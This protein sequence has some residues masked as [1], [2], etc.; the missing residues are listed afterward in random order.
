M[1]TCF[2][3]Y[4]R[5]QVAKIVSGSCFGE[6]LSSEL[7]MLEGPT[8]TKVQHANSQSPLVTTPMAHGIDALQQPAHHLLHQIMR[9]LD[10]VHQSSKVL[11]PAI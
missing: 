8:Q 10:V 4:A 6:A 5:D 9:D 3:T 1:L 11:A 7:S 2:V